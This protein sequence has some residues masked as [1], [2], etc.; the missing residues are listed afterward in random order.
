[1]HGQLLI[2]GHRSW[3]SLAVEAS[4]LPEVVE[5]LLMGAGGE[6]VGKFSGRWSASGA[7]GTYELFS[8]ETGSRS[9]PSAAPDTPPTAEREPALP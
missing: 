8:G 9:L 6:V 5:G 3:N 2:L 7:K 4:A 1:M